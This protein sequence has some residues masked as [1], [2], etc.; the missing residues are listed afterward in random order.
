MPVIEPSY[1]QEVASLDMT[2][3]A[4]SRFTVAEGR[5]GNQLRS[6]IPYRNHWL[7][8]GMDNVPGTHSADADASLLTSD[9]YVRELDIVID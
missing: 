8:G 9:A 3:G 4:L 5:R 1:V 2:N 6:V 7:V